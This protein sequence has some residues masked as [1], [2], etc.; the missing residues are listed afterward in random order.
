MS[1]DEIKVAV[2]NISLDDRLHLAAYLKHLARVDTKE[3]RAALS[4][5]DRR[6]DA[7]HYVTLEQLREA[8]AA[9]EAKGL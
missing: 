4:A 8:S 2:E 7:G 9:L 3:N 5:A 1:L 6:I